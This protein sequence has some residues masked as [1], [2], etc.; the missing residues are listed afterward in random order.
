[1][2]KINVPIIQ[3][4]MAGGITTPELVA[5]VSN[6]GG[7]GMVGAGYLKPEALLQEI[8]AIKQLTDRPFGINLFVMK[9]PVVDQE[10]I[11]KT[12]SILKRYREALSLSSDITEYSY[13]DYFDEH[14]QII[15]D[16]KIPVCSF[17]FGIPSNG[18]ITRLKGNNTI[19][20]G[21]ATNVK[22]ALINEEGGM[23]ALVVQGSE[24]GGHRGSFLREDT[25]GNIGLMSLIPQVT[26]AV[27]IPIIAAGGIMDGRGLKAS[28]LLGAEA[29][30]MGT[31]FLTTSESG[32]NPLYKKAILEASD[33]ET[34]L[35]KAFSGK[36]ARGLQNKFIEEMK[37]YE[38]LLPDFP[39]V[40]TLTGEIR[41]AAAVNEMTAYMSLWSGQSP[42]LA[43][44]ESVAS[45]MKRVMEHDP[46]N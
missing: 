7:L 46:F 21:T 9:K 2:L 30:Q 1:M 43:K 41:K 44:A 40:N 25:S 39:I 32:A 17:T 13:V 8:K 20:I 45:L 36:Y 23:D 12:I 15:L 14:V 27:Q 42:T 18:T 34:V 6:G 11:D 22:E 24:A 37:E 38:G 10:K 31:A 29:V 28:L 5:A 19:M 16:E 33:D 4:P 3:A 35:T 26:D